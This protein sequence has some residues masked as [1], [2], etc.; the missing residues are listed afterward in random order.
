M[1]LILDATPPGGDDRRVTHRPVHAW[2]DGQTAA[3][4]HEE[5][6]LRHL[7]DNHAGPL[8]GF[9]LRLTNGDR[10]RAED[11]VQETLLRAWRNAHKL[12]AHGERSL[13][14]WLVT[15]ARRIAID[16][17]RFDGARP[18]EVY[19]PNLETDL[20]AEPDE[21]DR[22]LALITINESLRALTPA[23]REILIE[24]YFKGRTVSEAATELGLPIG[25]AKSRVYYALRALREALEQR[26]LTNDD[27]Q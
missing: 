8:L 2:Q 6:L 23:H 19:D 18:R 16:D 3:M 1:R 13:R 22:L 15:V 10:Q 26:G 7:Y 24:T 11:I 4:S 9:V 27:N 20:V 21:T 12:G 17:Y 25:T 5:S 14:P